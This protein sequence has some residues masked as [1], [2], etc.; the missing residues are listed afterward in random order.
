MNPSLK[1]NVLCNEWCY[2]TNV[3]FITTV[4][5]MK[6]NVNVNVS[7]IQIRTGSS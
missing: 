5:S 2:D 4:E 3:K 1:V 7:E 6:V